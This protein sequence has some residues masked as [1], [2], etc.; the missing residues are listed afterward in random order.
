MNELILKNLNSKQKK[1]FKVDFIGIGAQKCATTWVAKCLSQHPQ[2]CF[3]K[4]KEL[5]F[6]N[7]K[8]NFYHERKDWQYLKG[9]SW[10]LDQFKHCSIASIKG[11]FSTHYHHDPKTPALIK[12]HFPNIKLIFIVRNPTERL[13]SSYFQGKFDGK[14]K[15]KLPDI[16]KIIKEKTDFIETGFYIDHIKRYLRY[17]SKEQ[18]LILIYEDIKRDPQKFIKSIYNFLNVDDNFVPESLNKRVNVTGPKTS[19]L[20]SNYI[21][22]KNKIMSSKIKKNI[23]FFLKPLKLNK[24]ILKIVFDPTDKLIKKYTHNK[25]KKGVPKE[26][27]KELN[28]TYQ[29]KNKELEIFLNRKLEWSE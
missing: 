21:N 9:I 14:R 29:D 2:I 7:K 8:A 12:E 4:N 27:I 22:W 23:M 10:Y 17:F 20:R 19:L 18:L 25:E 5:H 28:Q 1:Q 15:R 13:I 11:E 3:P 6:Y 16:K 26:I 24:L